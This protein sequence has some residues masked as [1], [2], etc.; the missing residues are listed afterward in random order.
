MAE[1]VTADYLERVFEEVKNWGKWGRDDERGALNYI[2]EKKRTAAAALIRDGVAV[3][4]ALDFPVEPSPDNPYPAQH[5]MVAAG[6][7]CTDP[8]HGGLQMSADFIGIAFHGLASS[9]IDALCHVF[10]REQMYNGFGAGDVL[11]IGATRNS[12]MAVRDGITGRGVLLD[13]PRLRGVE[14]L[15]LGHRVDVDELEAAEKEQGVRIEEGDILLIGTGR[16][17]RRAALG[18][19]E[20]V[21]DGLA[22]IDP[23]CIPW[24]HERRIAVL[25]CDGISDPLPGSGVEDWPAPVH[26]CCLVAMGVHLLDNLE[27]GTLA[28]GCAERNRWEFF[29]SVAPLRIPGGTGS[30]VNPIAVF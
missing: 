17:A 18:R 9:H 5:M 12:I 16:D 3:S 28:G 20:P 15:E 1:A 27:L 8:R 11:S 4:C 29:L 10:V 23:R 19:W 14:W 21:A 25:G 7:A 24:F 2:T 13:I 6:D 22:G 26:Q 30:P